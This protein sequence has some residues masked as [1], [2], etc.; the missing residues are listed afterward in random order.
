MYILFDI[1]VDYGDKI[2]RILGPYTEFTPGLPFNVSDVNLQ[3]ANLSGISE[4]YQ[5]K[6]HLG[7]DQ[8]VQFISTYLLIYIYSICYIIKSWN[9]ESR[10]S[11]V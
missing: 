2:T 8:D 7:F 10:S 3:C 1:K 9:V 11:S 4:K 5:Q 6:Y